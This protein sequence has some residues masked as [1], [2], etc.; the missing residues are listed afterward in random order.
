MSSLVDIAASDG[1]HSDATQNTE[2]Q[3]KKAAERRR[4]NRSS[5]A[6]RS[7]PRPRGPPSAS[8]GAQS[9]YDLD[10]E[11]IAV[12]QAL[13]RERLASA[14]RHVPRVVDTIGETI[15]RRFEEFLES[16]IEESSPSVPLSSAQTA[17]T[18]KYYIEQI[19][20]SVEHARTGPSAC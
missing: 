8:E 4:L 2:I 17:S 5:S 19:H 15:A 6:P 7:S 20:V 3:R 12:K 10:D 13:K 14:H 9:E 11:E 18:D 16:W 1:P